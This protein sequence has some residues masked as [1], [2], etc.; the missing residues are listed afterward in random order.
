M[1][2]QIDDDMK[3]PAG[4]TC[5]NCLRFR[6]CRTMISREGPETMCDWAPSG[7]SLGTAGV[8]T[9]QAQLTASGL[10]TQSAMD[11][12]ANAHAQIENLQAEIEALQS[13]IYQQHVAIQDLTQPNPAVD[14][15]WEAVENLYDVL[16]HEVT[17]TTVEGFATDMAGIAEAVQTVYDAWSVMLG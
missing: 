3:L 5:S 15:V 4:Y 12:L 14:H 9:L 17:A 13:E 8:G 7:F 1:S 11:A 6:S 10:A 2:N 16:N